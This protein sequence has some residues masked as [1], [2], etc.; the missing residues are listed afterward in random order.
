[1][2]SLEEIFESL[3]LTS[4]GCKEMLVCLLAKVF[5]FHTT[6]PAHFNASS[7]KDPKE[8][9]PLSQQVLDLLEV[10]TALVTQYE[11]LYVCTYELLLTTSNNLLFRWM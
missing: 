10:D 3:H 2:R 8:F 4:D 7:F 5:T 9:S 6:I 11:L 1:M